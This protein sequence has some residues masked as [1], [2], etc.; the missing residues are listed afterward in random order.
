MNFGIITFMRKTYFLLS[1][2]FLSFPSSSNSILKLEKTK[3]YSSDFDYLPTLNNKAFK[4]GEELTY[5]LHYGFLDAAYVNLN[6]TNEKTKFKGRETFH[7]IGI[8]KTTGITDWIFKVRDRYETYIDEKS[9]VPWLFKR[10][11]NEGGYIINQDYSFDRYKN[12]VITENR[13]EYYVSDNMQDMLSAYYQARTLDLSNI[14][15]NDVIS[16]NC[17]ID[18]E[19]FPVKIKFEGLQM[20]EIK[21]G[22]F[23]CLKFT[24]IIQTGRIFKD[25]NDLSLFISNDENHILIK[26]EADILF[27]TIEVELT[28]FN[29][30]LNKLN[31]KII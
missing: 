8:G 26:A 11:V 2:I 30:L 20:V 22:K 5:K 10:R 17:F 31:C 4:R 24:P 7:V 16:L 6:I 29:G 15:Q 3:A 25:E 28:E 19:V 13:K 14:K 1:T 27:G 12:K 21:L 18:D 9:L 23:K